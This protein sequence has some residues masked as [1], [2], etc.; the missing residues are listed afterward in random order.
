MFEAFWL[1]SDSFTARVRLGLLVD[2]IE[3]GTGLTILPVSCRDSLDRAIR[4]TSLC[5][6]L[7]QLC[8]MF[9]RCLQ[10]L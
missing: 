10:G 1:R 7:K 9:T 6:S 8:I 5:F 2:A 4:S 3:A